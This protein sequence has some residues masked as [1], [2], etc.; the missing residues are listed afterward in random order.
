M[1][2][3]I[4]TIAGGSQQVLFDSTLV[5]PTELRKNAAELATSILAVLPDAASILFDD[6]EMY[7]WSSGDTTALGALDDTLV[8]FLDGASSEAAQIKAG[9]ATTKSKPV[10]TVGN[11]V[12]FG[13]SSAGYDAMSAG[14]LQKACFAFAEP[15]V[16][17]FSLTQIVREVFDSGVEHM[18]DVSQNGGFPICHISQANGVVSLFDHLSNLDNID[19]SVAGNSGHVIADAVGHFQFTPVPEAGVAASNLPFE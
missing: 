18:E 17:K 14:S 12:P 5:D 13:V 9:T 4:V 3:K 8:S 11:V 7:V 15:K 10:V 2:D 6:T 1:D 16:P 19:L